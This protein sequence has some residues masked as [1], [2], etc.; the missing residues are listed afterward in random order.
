MWS[1]MK[2]DSWQTDSLH[3]RNRCSHFIGIILYTRSL[4]ISG[5][6]LLTAGDQIQLWQS[7]DQTAAQEDDAG[8][9]FFLEEHDDV[10][11]W[12]CIWRCQTS[13]PVTLI[14]FSPDGLL[15]ASIGKVL[16][17]LLANLHSYIISFHIILCYVMLCYVMLCYVMLYYFKLYYIFIYYIILYCPFPLSRVLIKRSE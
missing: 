5:S 16:S 9:E 17:W 2:P 6:K 15:F 13:I 1:L 4:V 11:E 3:L 8:V 12:S 14:R 7:P 10:L